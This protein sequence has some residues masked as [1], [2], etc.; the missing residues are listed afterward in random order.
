MTTIIYLIKKNRQHL[1]GVRR[2]LF[3]GG[4]AQRRRKL[5][6]VDGAGHHG[7]ADQRADH[8]HRLFASLAVAPVGQ[9]AGDATSTMRS[10]VCCLRLAADFL[11]SLY[12]MV[13]I[14]YFFQTCTPPLAEPFV[15]V[16]ERPRL[17]ALYASPA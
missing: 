14:F 10:C 17:A 2:Q 1:S 7:G 13:I 11:D 15:E 6:I 16:L 4:V 8:R 12:M 9:L 5:G 3:G